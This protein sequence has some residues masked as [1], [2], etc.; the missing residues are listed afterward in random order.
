MLCADQME[1]I[2]QVVV[3]SDNKW[4]G[5]GVR[6]VGLLLVAAFILPWLCAKS[7]RVLQVLGTITLLSVLYTMLAIICLCPSETHSQVGSSLENFELNLV[8]YSMKVQIKGILSLEGTLP[9]A[10]SQRGRA[11]ENKLRARRGLKLRGG[12]GGG[13]KGHGQV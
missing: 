2:G 6:R 4:H 11:L 5:Q 10:I 13:T 7:I 9:R 3:E 1:K 8:I 12:G